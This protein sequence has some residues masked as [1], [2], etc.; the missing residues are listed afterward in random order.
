MSE[1]AATATS[2]IS[3]VLHPTDLTSSSEL[4][5]AHAL[6]LAASGRTKLYLLHADPSAEDT[7][8][9]AYP[10]V[11]RTLASWGMLDEGSLPSVVF[12]QLG[13]QVAKVRIPDR[14]NAMPPDR[15]ADAARALGMRVE[16][17][18]SVEAA[19]HS[20]A[21]LAYEVPPRILITGSLYLAGHVL[22]A[23]GTPPG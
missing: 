16:T 11:R 3:A 2:Q 15:L 20:L 14:D 8:W 21:S 13:V 10:A 18:A 7:D 23:N 12:D 1:G 17:S 22:S 6:R 5:F 4:A 19:L 9:S